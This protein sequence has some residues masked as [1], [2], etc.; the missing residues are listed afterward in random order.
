MFSHIFIGITDF[1]RALAFYSPLMASLGIEARFCE[2]ERPWAGWQSAGAA[3]P[4]FLIGKPY[5]QHRSEERRVG[6]EC[7]L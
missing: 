4:L 7:R 6:K 2:P 3:R 1:K 5:D